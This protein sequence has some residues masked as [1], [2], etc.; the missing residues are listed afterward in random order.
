MNKTLATLTLALL[1]VSTLNAFAQT[2]ATTSASPVPRA[3]SAAPNADTSTTAMHRAAGKF[4]KLDTNG[5]GLI[6]REEV[7]SRP[8]LPKNFDTIDTNKD[9]KLSIEELKAYSQ[10]RK[11]QRMRQPTGENSAPKP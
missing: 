3:T 6:S 9:G 8:G 4:K 5:D 7:A 2:T 11:S 10:M 1:S